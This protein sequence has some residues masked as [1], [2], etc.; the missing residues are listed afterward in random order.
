MSENEINNQS[1][2]ENS[3]PIKE[4]YD[5]L[6]EIYLGPT[7]ASTDL[8]DE[9]EKK[10]ENEKEG[11]TFHWIQLIIGLFLCFSWYAG[12]NNFL[13]TTLY[14]AI[15]CI[16]HELG[17]VVIAKSFGCVIKEMQVFLCAFVSYKPKLIPGGSSWRDITWS[18]GVL[19]FGGLTIF[20]SREQEDQE[21]DM[22]YYQ[23]PEQESEEMEL[24]A[25]TS[26]YIDDKPAWQ[27]LLISAAG[28]LLNF[29]TYLV[30]Y[31]LIPYLP[32]E[33]CQA[34]WPLAV[35]SLIIAVLNIIPVYPLDGGR[36]M[37]EFIEM[38]TGKKPSQE[39]SQFLGWVG[40][41]FILFFFWIHPE[42]ING[43]LDSILQG[44]I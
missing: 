16:I 41:L 42:W 11:F 38:L 20:K 39:F 34:C 26:P 43:V 4:G 22:W 31:I 30:I 27:R 18:L 15:V 5:R 8:Y 2:E 28:V 40:F 10:D 24:T 37:L 14:F 1:M 35:M 44:Y 33:W 6:S 29:A 36:I 21:K 9:D 23:E 13:I 25:A 17:H 12:N 3:M 19:P 7:P 32:L